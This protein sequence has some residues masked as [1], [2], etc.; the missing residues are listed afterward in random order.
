M[1]SVMHPLIFEN[2][3][4]ALPISKEDYAIFVT[5]FLALDCFL[6]QFSS[7]RKDGWIE[8]TTTFCPSAFTRI[9]VNFDGRV[10]ESQSDKFPGANRAICTQFSS[11]STFLYVH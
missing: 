7:T 10:R 9:C 2:F 3:Q 5:R 4:F 8:Y 6:F 1:G 11:L